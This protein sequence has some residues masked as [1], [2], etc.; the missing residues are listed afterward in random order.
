M[1][2]LSLSSKFVPKHRVSALVCWVRTP[3]PLSCYDSWI[4]SVVPC[5]VIITAQVLL[6]TVVPLED[7]VISP[8]LESVASI[9]FGFSPLVLC[10]R[11]E[12]S[13]VPFHLLLKSS[14]RTVCGGGHSM[15]RSAEM[16]QMPHDDNDRGMWTL[17]TQPMTQGCGQSMDIS[18]TWYKPNLFLQRNS[19]HFDRNCS[20][21]RPQLDIAVTVTNQKAHDTVISLS[22]LF[23]KIKHYLL[24]L[25]ECQTRIQWISS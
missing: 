22:L 8:G 18:V 10:G 20:L 1:G 21:H 25:T 17:L 15:R 16:L 2:L 6:L 13:S 12:R 14:I 7:K 11:L 19:L 4:I 5:I 3:V 24:K 23:S 9:F